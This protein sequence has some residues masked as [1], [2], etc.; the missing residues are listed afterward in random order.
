MEEII[1]SKEQSNTRLDKFLNLHFPE[2]TRNHIQKCIKNGE[3]LVNSKAVKPSYDLKENDQIT[4][5][6]IEP[7]EVDILP[8]N[9]PL[10]IIYEDSDILI[11]NKPKGMVVHPAPGHYT[12]TLV[13]AI[14]YHCKDNLSGING[15]IRPGIVHRIDK[16]TTGSLIICKNDMAHNFIGEQIKEHSITRKYVGIVYGTFDTPEGVVDAPIGRANND[17]K[18]MCVTQK[19]SKNAITHY[20]VLK[21]N[22]K[23]SLVEFTLETGRTHQIR[24]HMSYINH[25]LL[26]DE[27]Y[28]PKKVVSNFRGIEIVGQCLHAKYIKFIH[29][30][31]R[32]NVEFTAPL[33]K[34]FQDIIDEMFGDLD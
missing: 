5:Q 17:R 7:K 28:G 34:Y 29:P 24:V 27:I 32:E 16:N 30:S 10:E 26:G 33:P 3:I 9:I 8:E 11:V 1:I 19:N 21:S 4:I 31:T 12:G 2:L 25:P 14:M 22:A 15:E 6:N 13:N 18:K 23:Y 20:K